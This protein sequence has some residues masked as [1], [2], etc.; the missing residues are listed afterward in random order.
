MKR[1]APILLAC[2]CHA[3]IAAAQSYPTRPITI[4]VTAAAGGVTDVVARAIG[5]RF[6]QTAETSGENPG[7]GRTLGVFTPI[8][9]PLQPAAE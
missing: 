2:V 7:I 1:L 4:T 5:Q 8:G 6:G 9:V 3:H